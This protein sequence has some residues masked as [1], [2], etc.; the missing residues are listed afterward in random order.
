APM[1]GHPG[2][3]PGPDTELDDAVETIAHASREP[4]PEIPGQR[5]VRVSDFQEAKKC[6]LVALASQSL[7]CTVRHTPAE[8]FSQQE[9]GT[10]R[11]DGLHG[12]DILGDHVLEALMTVRAIV[13]SFRLKPVERICGAHESSELDK[14]DQIHPKTA[15]VGKTEQQWAALAGLQPHP[16]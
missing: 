16:V 1:D 2:P 13:R 15:E 10:V 11:L 5:L 14:S 4:I 9:I 7:S 12:N 8:A 3:K 6:H